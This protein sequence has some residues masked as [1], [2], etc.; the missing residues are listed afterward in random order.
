MVYIE[1]EINLTVLLHDSQVN[2]VDQILRVDRS[3]DLNLP[4]QLLHIAGLRTNLLGAKG[5]KGRVV[6]DTVLVDVINGRLIHLFA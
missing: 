3:N 2:Q 1:I 5:C 6:D 4:S